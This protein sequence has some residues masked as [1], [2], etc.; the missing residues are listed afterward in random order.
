MFKWVSLFVLVL[1][2]SMPF[3]EGHLSLGAAVVQW[4]ERH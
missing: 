2:V 1:M 4:L 3:E